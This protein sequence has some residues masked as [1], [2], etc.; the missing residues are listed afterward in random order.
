[1][2]KFEWLFRF[3][4]IISIVRNRPGITFRELHERVM[5]EL[6][7]R[8]YEHYDIDEST[9]KRDL[10]VVRDELKVPIVHRPG[11]PGYYMPDNWEKDS[12]GLNYLLETF[13]ILN[14]LGA[15][16]NIKDIVL[17]DRRTADGASHLP[18]L[19][20]AIEERRLVRFR[21][22]KFE[23]GAPTSPEVAPYAVKN[24]R[25]RWYVLGIKRGEHILKAFGLDRL[26]ELVKLRETFVRRED[27]DPRKK[28]EDCFG[29]VD[30]ERCPVEN[31][32]LKFS[33]YDG[34]YLKT[35]WLHSSQNIV[36]HDEEKDSCIITLRVR[37]TWDFKMELLSRISSLEVLEP[38]SLREEIA[39]LCREAA[40]RNKGLPAH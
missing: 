22:Q 27:V 4:F 1:M 2:K 25:N 19:I 26:T 10:R 31:V 11:I 8:G 32:K 28:Y 30:D 37:L 36:E 17:T 40:G 5:E 23:G 13:D 39:R 24:W 15:N 20:R 3:S 6:E 34:Q 38:Q 14:A 33:Y 12:E 7:E 18:L 9:L 29:I 35:L 16:S 21:Y